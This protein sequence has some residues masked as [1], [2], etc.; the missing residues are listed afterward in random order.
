MLVL[1][2]VEYPERRLLNFF[3]PRTDSKMFNQL[4]VR[5]LLPKAILLAYCLVLMSVNASGA[6]PKQEKDSSIRSSDATVRPISQE[7]RNLFNRC[8]YVSLQLIL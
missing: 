5:D 7:L 6:E 4:Q 2:C 8:R 3:Q 1:G